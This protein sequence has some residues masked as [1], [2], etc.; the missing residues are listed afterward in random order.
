[1]PTSTRHNTGGGEDLL[2]AILAGE[3]FWPTEPQSLH[4]TGLSEPFLEGLVCRHLLAQG[5]CSGR[6]MATL[7]GLPIRIVDPILDRLRSMQVIVHRGSG[8]LNDYVYALT[9]EGRKRAVA[10]QQDCAYVGPA[11]V[12]LMDYVIS[13]EAQAV[14]DEP[15][16]RAELL[17]AFHD[18]SVSPALLD[19]LGPA[20]NSGGG[21]FLYGAPGNGKSTIAHRITSCYGSQ[22]WVP[23]AFVVEQEIVKVYDPAHHR[24]TEADGE[25]AEGLSFDRRWVRVQRPTVVVGGE[26][27]LDNL[28]IR[29]DPHT[30]VSEAPLHLKSNCGC[31]L[32]DDFGRQRV[33]P[34]DLLNRWIIPLENRHDFLTMGNGKKISVPFEQ[35]IIFSTNLDP[36]DLVDEAFLR[37]IPYRL[38]VTD[39]AEEEFYTLFQ[40]AC[41]RQG[42]DYDPDAVRHLLETYYRPKNRPLR[43]CHP[44]DVLSQIRYY[45]VYNSLPFELR[46]EHVDHVA[47]GFFTDVPTRTR[48]RGRNGRDE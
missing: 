48:A 31:L 10:S 34:E 38:E 15:I 32:I 29:F 44:R 18:I 35:L 30:K 13:V 46:P 2:S 22:I 23:H 24:L 26:L 41:D 8:P 42:C 45:C 28:E 4:D 40:L 17:D 36:A 1:M 20:V 7:V 21:L 39:P 12:P 33:S 14:R 3:R 11:P 25:G 5:S 37:R 43:R 6:R 16:L 47:K 27:T 9:E 19:L